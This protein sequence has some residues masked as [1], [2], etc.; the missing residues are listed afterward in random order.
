VSLISVQAAF[1]RLLAC[2]RDGWQARDRLAIAVWRNDV[3]L[4]RDGT[5][6]SPTEIQD[7][8]LYVRAAVEADGRWSCTIAARPTAFWATVLSADGDTVCVVLPAPP[9]W[10]V[11]DDEIAALIKHKPRQKPGRRPTGNWPNLIS[12][13]LRR[14]DRKLLLE[15][16]NAGKLRGHLEAVLDDKLGWHPEDPRQLNAIIK[17]FLPGE[18]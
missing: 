3:R 5:L 8:G 4:W 15:L 12:G 9:L 10:E 11:D 17:G 16:H 1:D 2:E 13:H 18:M 14:M 7:E 6:V